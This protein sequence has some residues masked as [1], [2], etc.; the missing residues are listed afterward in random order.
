MVFYEGRLIAGRA[1]QARS[2]SSPSHAVTVCPPSPAPAPDRTLLQRLSMEAPNS[3]HFTFI[4][5]AQTRKKAR[6][7]SYA[8]SSSTPGIGSPPPGYGSLPDGPSSPPPGYRSGYGSPPTGYDSPQTAGPVSTSPS[9]K[10]PN[11]P[12]KRKRI[13]VSRPV[14]LFV[15]KRVPPHTF[16]GGLAVGWSGSLNVE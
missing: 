1:F 7:N 8:A 11:R 5:P 15:G 16:G 9:P 4:R 3:G 12:Q 14:S 10:P 6:L 2:P 13:L